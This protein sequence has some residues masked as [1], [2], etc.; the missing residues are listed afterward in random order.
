MFSMLAVAD[1]LAPARFVVMAA[2]QVVKYGRLSARVAWSPL[3]VRQS[4][5]LVDE[6]TVW[7]SVARVG[8]PCARRR[9][10]RPVTTNNDQHDVNNAARVED[11]A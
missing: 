4:P 3:S 9:T 11:Y 5:A 7:V 2:A 1:L 10:R 6:P 8:L